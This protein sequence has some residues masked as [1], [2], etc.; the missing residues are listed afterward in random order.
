MGLLKYGTFTDKIKAKIRGSIDL[1]RLVKD[2]LVI[3]ENFHAQEGVII[4][5]GHCWLIEIGDNVTLAPRVHILAHDASTKNLIGY[6]KIGKVKIGSDVFVGAGT[7]ILPGVEIPDHSII[8]AGSLVTKSLSCSGVY[9][10]SPV[11]L[12]SSYSEYKDKMEK[13]MK[14]Y[15]IYD[16][17]YTINMINEKRINEMKLELTGKGGFVV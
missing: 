13:R 17:M 12:V 1:D 3:G 2:G 6:T 16:E 14:D 5:P 4:D 7:I 15:P 11:R 10:G 8:G 9:I